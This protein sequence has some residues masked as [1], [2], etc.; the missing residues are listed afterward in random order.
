MTSYSSRFWLYA[1]T[2]L[3]LAIAAAVMVHWWLRADAFEKRLAAIKGREAVP[4]ITL[5]W[6]RVEVGGFPFRLDAGFTDFR[7][8]GAGAHGPFAWQS[9]KF[10]LHALTY[11]RRQDVFEAAGRQTVAW[12]EADGRAG[13]ASF[14]PGSLHASAITDAN[15][16]ARADLDIVDAGAKDFTVARFQLHMRRDPLMEGRGG[17][18]DLML[19][20]DSIKGFGVDQPLVEIYATL[21]KAAALAPL[22]AGAKAWPAAVGDWRAQGGAAKLTRITAPGLSPDRLL[23]VFY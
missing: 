12:T 19:R 17:G 14:L 9:E 2:A 4:G 5:D 13:A 3:F 21:N 8:K 1:P 16:L 7:V 10:A 6:T 22:L 23:S 15:G 20:A 18:L 11:G